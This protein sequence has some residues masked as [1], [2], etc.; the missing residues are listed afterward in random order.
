MIE[1]RME[2]LNR[3]VQLTRNASTNL[4]EKRQD[5]NDDDFLS[6][7]SAFSSY[8]HLLNLTS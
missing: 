1:Q 6:F 5:F 7:R 3:L 4:Y 2:Q 8:E